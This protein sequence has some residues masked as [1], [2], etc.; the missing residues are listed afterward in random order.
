MIDQW[1]DHF[2]MKDDKEDEGDNSDDQSSQED[3]AEKGSQDG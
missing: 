2:N 3:A 1:G